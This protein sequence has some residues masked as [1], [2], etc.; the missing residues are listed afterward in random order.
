M[1]GSS[2]NFYIVP[3]IILFAAIIVLSLVIIIAHWI[4]DRR[5]PR[6]A[7]QATIS[8][9]RIQKDYVSRQRNAAPG[10]HSHRMLTYYVTFD[11]ETCEH[12]ELRVSK[13]KYAELKK[14][15]SGKLTYQGTRYI[16]FERLPK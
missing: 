2:E 9:K 3:F 10:M 4:K 15:S 7:V 14:G 13:L 8:D 1:F 6:I 12:I 5:S 16:G 11:L